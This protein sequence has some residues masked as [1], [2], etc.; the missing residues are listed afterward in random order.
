MVQPIPPLALTAILAALMIPLSWLAPSLPFG[1]MARAVFFM[2]FGLPGALILGASVVQFR[3]RRTTVNPLKPETATSLVTNGVYRLSRNPM[4]VGFA[5]LLT[6]WSLALA[7]PYA[8]VLALCFVVYINRLQIPPE[9]AAMMALFGDQ[10][11]D[12]K[13]QVRRWL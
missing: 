13:T 12:Y 3:L 11:S 2:F 4:Y 9:E 6:G 10:F 1:A 5:A 8:L 7:S